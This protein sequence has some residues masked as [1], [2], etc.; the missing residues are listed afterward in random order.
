MARVTRTKGGEKNTKSGQ[1]WTRDEL[2]KVLQLYLNDRQLKVHESNIT[3]Q[4]LAEEL[5][6]TTRS[7]EAQ[8]LMFRNLDKFGFY[9]YG[10]MNK[11]CRELWS[12][13]IDSSIK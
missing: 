6:R 2:G 11:I 1:K 13:Y 9:G 7:V 3:I 4:N 10:N 8:L 12:E 5:G